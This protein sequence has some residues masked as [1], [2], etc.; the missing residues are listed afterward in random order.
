L[1]PRLAETLGRARV[2]ERVLRAQV[3]ATL[4][5][6]AAHGEPSPLDSV[7]KLVLSWAEQEIFGAMRELLGPMLNDRASNA[8]GV[9]AMS[10]GRDYLYGRAA[11]IYGGTRQIQRNIVADRLLGLPRD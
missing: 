9:R 11:S 1:P 10:A 8:W 7:D 6:A 4:D 5:R 2:A 3:I